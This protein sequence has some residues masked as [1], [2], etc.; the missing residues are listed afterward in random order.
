MP[1]V[2]N[3]VCESRDMLGFRV[4]MNAAG[5]IYDKRIGIFNKSIVDFRW[6]EKS[7][8]VRLVDRLTSRRCNSLRQRK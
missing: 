6:I 4:G 2:G 8:R 3:G 7:D 5:Q 1:T